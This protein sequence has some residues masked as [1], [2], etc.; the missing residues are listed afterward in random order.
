MFRFKVQKKITCRLRDCKIIWKSFHWYLWML[1]SMNV[2]GKSF[3][4]TRKIENFIT[5]TFID[6]VRMSIVRNEKYVVVILKLLAGT[7]D[8]KS[9]CKLK[10]L[11]SIKKYFIST[12]FNLFITWNI[13]W[14]CVCTQFIKRRF[15]Q[16]LLNSLKDGYSQLMCVTF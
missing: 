13:T 15:F 4:E 16:I 8:L 11:N 2:P 14:V 3:K 9:H 1:C 10:Y 7:S 12:K 6:D 5:K